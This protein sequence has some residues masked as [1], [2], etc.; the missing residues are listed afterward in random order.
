MEDSEIKLRTKHIRATADKGRAFSRWE[1]TEARKPKPK[2]E[3]DEDEPEEDEDE[4]NPNKLP[5]ESELVSRV[6]DE[7]SSIAAQL[8]NYNNAERPDF[9]Q[10][11]SGLYHSTYLR[12]F[13]AGLTPT[14]LAE[15][16]EYRLKPA[17]S[18]PLTPV[19]TIIEGAGD[20]KGLLTEGLAE[21]EDGDVIQLP[22]TWSLW[23]DV[24]PVLL[25]K[26]TVARG[27][28]EWACHFANNVFVFKSEENRNEFVKEPRKF[29]MASP[30]MPP[31]YRV[32]MLGPSCSGVHSQA[33]KL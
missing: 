23:R 25:Q 1:R 16:I 24:D 6:C 31:E 21:N 20:K 27:E 15:T 33:E 5:A 26:G 8:D 11:I 19:A 9:D 3:D 29:L 14:E 7:E 13:A 17:V 18:E 12:I 10:Q 32:L 2:G 30:E 22:R 28:A 4:E